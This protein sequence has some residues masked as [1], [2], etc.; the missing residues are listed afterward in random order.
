[1]GS[2]SCRRTRLRGSSSSYRRARPPSPF[3]RRSRRCSWPMWSRVTLRPST[4]QGGVQRR[5]HERRAAA[6]PRLGREAAR[7]AR[8]GDRTARRRHAGGTALTGVPLAVCGQ[9]LF[10]LKRRRH[11]C[12]PVRGGGVLGDTV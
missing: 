2:T 5:A 10:V 4:R 12:R 3:G 8:R 7:A 9:S 6:Q 11:R 1:M